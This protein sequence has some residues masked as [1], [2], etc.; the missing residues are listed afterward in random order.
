MNYKDVIVRA[1]KTFLQ[2]FLGSML[3]S[4]N[5]VTNGILYVIAIGTWR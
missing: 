1:L 5:N 2:A 4:L 3:L